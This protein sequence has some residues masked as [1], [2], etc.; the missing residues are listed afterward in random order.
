MK[1]K[2]QSSKLKISSKVQAQNGPTDESFEFE[3]LDLKFPLSF[4]LWILS[5]PA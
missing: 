5:L 4:E 3:A 2:A 1:F